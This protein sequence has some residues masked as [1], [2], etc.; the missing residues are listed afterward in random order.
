[1]TQKTE[2]KTWWGI[3]RTTIKKENDGSAEVQE[4]ILCKPHFFWKKKS[5]AL[6]HAARYNQ[7]SF[8]GAG[9]FY[10]VIC[11]GVLP[12]LVQERGD[13]IKK[14]RGLKIGLIRN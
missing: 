3:K 12:D 13:F 1:M 9:A 14:I 7:H 6:S 4:T 11:V 8:Y 5:T 10:E 2:Q